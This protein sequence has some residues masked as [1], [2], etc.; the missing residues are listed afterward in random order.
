M[1]EIDGSYGEGGGQILRTSLALSLATGKPFFIKKVREGRKNPGL[2]HQHLSALEA[3]AAIG[4]AKVRGNSIG[5]KEIYFAPQS[6]KPGRYRF[7]VGTAGSSMLVLQTVLPAL[8]TG[9]KR[10]DLVIE[11]GTHNPHAPPFDF[12]AKVFLPILNRI[13]PKIKAILDRPGFYPAG[14]GSVRISIQPCE[15]L[16]PIESV[17]RG[18]IKKI[19]ARAVVAGLPLDIGE[20]ELKV[21]GKEFLLNRNGLCLDEVK[22]SRGPGNVLMIEI[23]SEHII[24]LFTGFG[25]RGLP[26]EKVAGKTAEAVR[27]YLDADVPVGKH[28]ADQLLIPMAL[29]KGGRFLTLPLTKHTMTNIEIIKQFLDVEIKVSHLRGKVWEISIDGG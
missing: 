17:E 13:G 23:A 6:I 3:A 11:G 21:I 16:S 2:M 5:S 19:I 25:Q 1:I 20:R 8:L 28:L 9:N 29:A 4:Q 12:L 7:A 26:A 10:S 15:K 24:E 22:N 18:K 14:G 27:E